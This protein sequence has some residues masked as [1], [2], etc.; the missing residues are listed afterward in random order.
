[1]FLQGKKKW[2]QGSEGDS[3]SWAGQRVE[4][5]EAPCGLKLSNTIILCPPQ[6]NCFYEW[7]ECAELEQLQV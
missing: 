1:M 6:T 7:G 2:W 4:R 5:S 3:W